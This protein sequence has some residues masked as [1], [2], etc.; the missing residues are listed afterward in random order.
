MSASALYSEPEALERLFDLAFNMGDELKVTCVSLTG[1]I[2]SATHYGSALHS[3]PSA[4]NRRIQLTTGHATTIA[5]VVLNV[6]NVLDVSRRSLAGETLGVLGLGSIGRSSLKLLLQLEGSPK[7][8]LLLDVFQ[9]QSDLETLRTELVKMGLG[10]SVEILSSDGKVPQAFY[11]STLML[12]ATN[13]GG[14]LDVDSLMPGTIVVDDSAPHCFNQIAA[15]SRMRAK[16]DVLL[17]EAGFLG[18][19]RKI[20]TLWYIPTVLR[21]RLQ[22][23]ALAELTKERP[24]ILTACMLSALF[25]CDESAFPR[26]IGVSDEETCKK[27]LHGLLNLGCKPSPLLLGTWLLPEDILAEFIG[28]GSTV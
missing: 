3:S 9:K 10:C 5:T 14:I 6:K 12:G 25:S 21:R 1:M 17:V 20:T 4:S 8:L 16:K 28:N 13:V 2:P 22:N 19:D 26:T 7:K 11:Q 24:P 27:H 18:M 23:T 15:I